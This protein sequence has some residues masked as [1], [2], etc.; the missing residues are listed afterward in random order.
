M[1]RAYSTGPDREVLIGSDYKPFYAKDRGTDLGVSTWPLDAWKIGGG[2]VSG[3]LSF[4]PDL[5]LVYYGT[6]NPAPWNAEQ[7][8]GD[9]KF[10]SGVFARDI[11]TGRARWFY[12]VS[13]H[14][15]FHYEAT[16]ENIL[17][18]LELPGGTRKTLLHPDRNGYLYVFD[19]LTGEVLSA[20][21]FVRVT[22]SAGVD[23]STGAL[24]YAPEKL[25]RANIVVRGICPSSAGGKNWQPSAWSPRTRL[26]Y[27]PHQN[28]CQDEEVMAT[29]FIAGTPYMGAI[30]KMKPGPGPGR[31]LVTAWDPVAKRAAWTVNEDFPVW[32]GALATAGD[33]VFYGTMDARPNPESSV[34]RSRIEDRTARS[35]SPCCRAW[36]AGPEP[37]CSTTSIRATAVPR[38]ALRTRCATSSSAPRREACSMCSHSLDGNTSAL[39]E[40]RMR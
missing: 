33:L 4:D 1:W 6:A 8:P 13:A 20:T 32:S 28:L 18:D 2:T 29:S 30:I 5:G 21:P 10:T 16:N 9:N 38:V 15:Q 35:T 14:D 7:R 11:V 3:W 27:I 40:E 12:Q 36:V 25:P 34:S 24:H 39:A 17:V 37:S 23:L 19:R 22:T 26:L 31:G